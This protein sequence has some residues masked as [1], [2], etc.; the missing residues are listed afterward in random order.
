VSAVHLSGLI[1]SRK[2]GRVN[3]ATDRGP[4]SGR[5]ARHRA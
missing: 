3:T 4:S 2:G 1:S 5:I